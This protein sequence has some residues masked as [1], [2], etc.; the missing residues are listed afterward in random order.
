MIGLD[1]NV[2]VR[3][4]TQDDPGQ[5]KAASL[6]MGS[7]SPEAPAFISL[8]VVTELIWVLEGSYSFGRKEL[9]QVLQALVVS[10]ELIIERTDSVVQALRMFRSSRADFADCLIERCGHCNGCDY[11]VTFD[12]K[13][14]TGAGMRLIG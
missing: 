14:A 1:T 7:L 2:L 4:I 8:I 9:D 13:A 3:Y 10:K 5:A 6:I 11:T 12:R